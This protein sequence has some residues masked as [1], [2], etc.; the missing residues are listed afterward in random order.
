MLTVLNREELRR[1]AALRPMIERTVRALAREQRA[2]IICRPMVGGFPAPWIVLLD[3][4]GIGMGLWTDELLPCA[5][6]LR[7][8]IVRVRCVA[9]IVN[10]FGG[11]SAFPLALSSMREPPAEWPRYSITIGA[12]VCVV[13]CSPGLP[14]TGLWETATELAIPRVRVPLWCDLPLL[15]ATELLLERVPVRIG[16]SNI[17]GWLRCADGGAMTIEI[18]EKLQEPGPAHAHAQVRVELG[19]IEL[20]LEELLS[21]RPG[22][23]LEIGAALPLACTL[24]VGATEIVRAMLEPSEAGFL[25]RISPKS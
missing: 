6:E 15:S 4:A 14:Q 18:V 3:E 2:E 11:A 7:R 10:A 22:S 21:L 19:V 5:T 25:L 20:T 13:A 23:V 17:Q 9:A 16:G 1:D 12:D 24:S 8:A